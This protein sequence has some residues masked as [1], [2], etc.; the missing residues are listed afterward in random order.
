MDVLQKLP[1]FE[2]HFHSSGMKTW[3]FSFLNAIRISKV[4]EH[5]INLKI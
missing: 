5:F 1:I 3:S 4:P 2:I